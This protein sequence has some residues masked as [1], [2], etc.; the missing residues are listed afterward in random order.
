[1]KFVRA[2]LLPQLG[3]DSPQRSRSGKLLCICLCQN[4]CQLLRRLA[5][6]FDSLLPGRRAKIL[7]GLLPAPLAR[8]P[9]FLPSWT[10]H[11]RP[12][13]EGE[14]RQRRRA[15]SGSKRS[16]RGM[17]LWGPTNS[18]STV[19]ILWPQLEVAEPC[20]QLHPPR[21]AAVDL[22]LVAIGLAQSW[23][24]EHRETFPWGASHRY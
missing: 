1:M 8:T 12:W 23:Q 13:Q 24:E 2:Q 17:R 15:H 3:F 18:A 10:L 16:K 20:A 6:G 14:A 22:I 7:C 9:C 21:H 19:T 5:R 11:Q 4:D